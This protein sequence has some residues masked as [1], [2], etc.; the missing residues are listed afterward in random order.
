[1]FTIL[2][3]MFVLIGLG[4]VWSWRPPARVDVD[5]TRRL[6]SNSVYYLFLP[7]LVLMV[8]W[9]APL[10]A[11][12]LKIAAS[13][14][15]GVI[16]AVALSWLACRAC[17]AQRDVTGA[18]ILAA[19][20]PN[21]TYLGLPVLESTFG[22]WA[23]SIAI[24]Y[25]LFACTPL[26]LTLGIV[27]AGRYGTVEGREHPLRALARVPPLWA[28]L[29]AVALNLGG[30]PMPAWI[31]GLLA[32]MAAPVVPL[33]L[34]SVGMALK[35]GFAQWRRLPL[36]VPVA[37]IQLLLMPL[38]VLGVVSLLGMSGE[39]RVAV[40]LE[41]AMP[42]MVL[43]IV[44]CDR[45]GLNTGVYAAALTATTLLSLVTLPAWYQWL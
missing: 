22:P 37:A 40:V 41:A 34:L 19:S 3:Q 13:A 23:R 35:Q 5:A 36:V 42:S 21:A 29:A 18:M 27:I 7:A 15:V 24:Q 30:V 25:D 17:R 26:L 32:M 9:R 31:D 12:T 4:L 43:G 11:D 14:A 16:G 10:G 1:M 20:W 38:L 6:L 44:L 28:A 33:M 8:L 2:L 45:Y 39:P